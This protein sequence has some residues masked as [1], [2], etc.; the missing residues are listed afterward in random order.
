MLT[1]TPRGFKGEPLRR[2]NPTPIRPL[3]QE[4]PTLR[5]PTSRGDTYALNWRSDP[6][7][8]AILART[9]QREMKAR[10]DRAPPPNRLPR[11]P[12]DRIG[13]SVKT[14]VGRFGPAPRRP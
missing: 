14:G 13:R 5:A 4:A 7:L 2:G 1:S 6:R 10:A 11:E 12:R 9:V 3:R 8:L